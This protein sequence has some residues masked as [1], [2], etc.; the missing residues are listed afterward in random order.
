M[1]MIIPCAKNS[2]SKLVFSNCCS[3]GPSCE[4]TPSENTPGIDS[5]NDRPNENDANV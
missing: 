3:F 1:F 4:N 5:N 2:I